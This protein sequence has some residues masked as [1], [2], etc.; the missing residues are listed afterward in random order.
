MINFPEIDETLVVNKR[1][2]AK[3]ERDTE[4]KG[5]KKRIKDSEFQRSG[6]WTSEEEQFAKGL[7]LDFERGTFF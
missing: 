3:R 4:V 6:K 1:K 7:I 5:Q 2:R